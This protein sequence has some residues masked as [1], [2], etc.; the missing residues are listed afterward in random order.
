MKILILD[1][2]A[3]VLKN[4]QI[5]LKPM[6]HECSIFQDPQKAILEF[7]KSPIDLLIVELNLPDISGLDVVNE[8]KK[9]INSISVIVIANYAHID[10]TIRAVNL[11]IDGFFIK[12]I[13]LEEFIATISKIEGKIF[14]SKNMK[15]ITGKVAEGDNKTKVISKNY[16]LI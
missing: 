8:I 12:P 13:N 14:S 5:A 11:G 15:M 16:C 1:D 4:L 3:Q 2:N 7:W 9:E 10:S 6:G